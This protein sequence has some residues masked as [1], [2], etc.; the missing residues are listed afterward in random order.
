MTEQQFD[1]LLCH[2]SEDKPAVSQIARQ[3]LQHGL[4]PWLAVWELQSALQ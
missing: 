3:L 1:V 2:N 4:R